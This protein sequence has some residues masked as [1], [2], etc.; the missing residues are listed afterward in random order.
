MLDNALELAKLT[1]KSLKDLKPND[2]WPAISVEQGSKLQSHFGGLCERASTAVPE[3]VD[4]VR[5]L[6]VKPV[7]GRAIVFWHESVEKNEVLLDVFH[8]GCPVK[9]GKKL[10][11][12][13]FKNFYPGHPECQKS[14]WCRVYF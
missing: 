2:P 6:A 5:P 7:P 12:Q 13:K 4:A 1:V 8:A 3:G 10:A 11:L 14:K 9:Q